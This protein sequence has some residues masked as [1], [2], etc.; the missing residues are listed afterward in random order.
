VVNNI[1]KFHLKTDF[2]AKNGLKGDIF[3]GT[4]SCKSYENF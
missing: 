2:L 1:K 4:A 3:D